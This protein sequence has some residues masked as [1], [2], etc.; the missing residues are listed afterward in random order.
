MLAADLISSDQSRMAHLA[1]CIVAN[2]GRPLDRA[3]LTGADAGRPGSRSGREGRPGARSRRRHLP[4]GRAL[5][6]GNFARAAAAADAR[7]RGGRRGRGKWARRR[8]AWK[9]RSVCLHYNISCGNC[10][11]CKAGNDQFCGSGRMIGHFTD[12]GWA[13]VYRRP[14]A[15]RASAAGGSALRTGCDAD[16][17]LRDVL[18]RA[19]Q[20]EA[21]ARRIRGG[22]RRGP[23]WARRRF[24]SPLNW[25][26]QR[27][28]YCNSK[29]RGV[30]L[31]F[32]MT[33]RV[34][35]A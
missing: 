13:G 6:H 8:P 17:R 1:Q 14:C 34:A 5:P 27:S 21:G 33:E 2:E 35:G 12:G 24:S 7:A 10:G 11:H 29:L 23:I 19:A 31:R 25:T 15:Q 3:R 18:S 16:V 26:R 32:W 9:W 20:V 28:T 4:F 30:S 22:L